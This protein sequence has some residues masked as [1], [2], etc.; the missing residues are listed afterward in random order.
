MSL[1]TTASGRTSASIDESREYCAA[2]TK[3]EARNFYYGFLLLPAE[4]RRALCALYA[5]MREVDDIS[6]FPGE[7]AEKRLRLAERKP[8]PDAD[9]VRPDA[10][11][12]CDPRRE[13]WR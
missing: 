9:P 3:R 11:Y 6:D 8:V 10:L 7:V 4:K 1:I 5:F 12:P 2:L 13:F